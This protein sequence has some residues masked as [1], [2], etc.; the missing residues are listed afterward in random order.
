MN[1]DDSLFGLNML[2][3][4]QQPVEGMLERLALGV[5]EFRSAQAAIAELVA[6][7]NDDDWLIY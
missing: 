4:P 1:A 3:R 2:A 7:S 5:A 6:E